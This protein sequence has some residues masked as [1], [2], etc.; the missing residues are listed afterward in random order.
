MTLDNV[1]LVFGAL[2]GFPALVALVIDVLKLLGV[3]SDGT[4]GKWN[5][6]FNLIGFILVGVAVGFYPEIDI[7]GLDYRL[8]ELVQIAA[9][10]VT[11][12]AQI[13]ATRIAHALYVKTKVGKKYLTYNS[14][15]SRLYEINAF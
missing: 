2:V 7:P 6:A 15:E 4:A 12:L 10:I 1:L 14:E 5:L 13:L 3:V 8:L 9:Y 11:V